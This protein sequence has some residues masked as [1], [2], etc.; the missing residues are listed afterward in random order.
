[1]SFIKNIFKG[2]ELDEE[3]S[4]CLQ[5]IHKK[6]LHTL[7]CNHKLHEKC[8][9]NLLKS[10]C[11]NR[12]PLCRRDIIENWA[13]N[14]EDNLENI[15]SG[16][17]CSICDNELDFNEENCD[18][19]K[20]NDCGCFYHYGCLK[21]KRKRGLNGTC[22]CG[23]EVNYENVDMLS[24]LYFLNGYLKIVGKMKCCK[25]A[26]CNIEGNPKRWGYC[27]E[28]HS[29]MTTNIAFAL[30]LQI[31]TRYVM[32]EE[33]EKRRKIFYGILSKLNEWGIGRGENVE[34]LRVRLGL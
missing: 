10:D 13:I 31:M 30:S 29:M 22:G 18:V 25:F 14:Q 4:I 3:C 17:Y 16:I 26:G 9:K 12:C 34:R 6:E 1:M 24:Y 23:Q 21:E 33:E 20:S 19:I 15:R 2:K 28:H 32:E 5:K 11:V 8:Y 27:A 7:R